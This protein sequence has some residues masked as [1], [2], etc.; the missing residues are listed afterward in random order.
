MHHAKSNNCPEVIFHTLPIVTF[1]MV[2]TSSVNVRQERPTVSTAAIYAAIVLFWGSL[3]F[4]ISFQ[5]GAIAPEVAVAYRFGLSGALILGW[6]IWRRKALKFSA[7]QHLILFGQGVIMFSL[8]DMLLYNAIAYITSGV[9][10]LVLSTLPIFNIFFASIFLGMRIR[11]PVFVGA[12]FGVSGIVMVFWPELSAFDL[13]S[14]SLI[15]FGLCLIATV[16]ASL[17]QIVSAYNQRSGLPPVETAGLCMLYGAAFS[18]LVSL[19]LGRNFTWDWSNDFLLSFGY[20]VIVCTVFAWVCYL[21]LIGR[22]GPDRAGYVSIL[23]PIIALVI[24]TLFEDFRWTMLSLA[25][26]GAIIS[27]SLFILLSFRNKTTGTRLQQ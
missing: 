14:T 24:S 18:V 12:I 25:G 11:P 22:I 19:C 10:A 5:V 7:R 16:S 1:G 2:I 13:T 8:T 17:A 20:I 26:A 27:G 23:V 21:I 3:Y 6:C 9:A 15:G 4:A